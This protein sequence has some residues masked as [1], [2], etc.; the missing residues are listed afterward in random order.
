LCTKHLGAMIFS[1]CLP[2]FRKNISQAQSW[3]N[4]PG[5]HG[6]N[7]ARRPTRGKRISF[8]LFSLSSFAPAGRRR[9]FDSSA[10]LGIT[11]SPGPPGHPLPS[12]KRGT[13]PRVALRAAAPPRLQAWLHPAAPLGP[14]T[15]HALRVGH[16]V[17][18][19]FM[20]FAWKD[21]TPLRVEAWHPASRGSMAPGF[22]W[23][24]DTRPVNGPASRSPGKATALL[25]TGGRD[26]SSVNCSTRAPRRGP[27][28]RGSAGPGWPP[29]P[30]GGGRRPWS[31]RSPSGRSGS[32][33]SPP[34][35]RAAPRAP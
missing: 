11:P 22:A 21:G 10:P 27:L 18:R 20:R 34:P 3:E 13:L 5:V 7:A 2:G 25:A 6:R 26:H 28:A 29:Q 12:R 8:V 19:C 16:G 14:K 24:Q 31:G 30:W 35:G 1:S 33:R 4:P 23:K 32:A 15:F 17:K 9:F